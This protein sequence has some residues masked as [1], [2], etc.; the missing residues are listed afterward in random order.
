MRKKPEGWV[1]ER[2]HRWCSHEMKKQGKCTCDRWD[3]QMEMAGQDPLIVAAYTRG[4]DWCIENGFQETANDRS[5]VNK[6]ARDYADYITSTMLLPAKPTG[7]VAAL[8]DGQT[9][10][11]EDG[12]MV[13]VSRQ[14]VD[15]VLAYVER[16]ERTLTGH[17]VGGPI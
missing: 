5:M 2:A 10:I 11:D 13:G 8:R 3:K 12:V 16:L 9:Q 1:C 4:F 17:V 7:A 14:A 6:A 15:E